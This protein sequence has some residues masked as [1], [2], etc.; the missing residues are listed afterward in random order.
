MKK[1]VKIVLVLAAGGAAVYFLR[2]KSANAS[3]S[4]AQE[5]EGP[6][7]DYAGEAVDTGTPQGSG[8]PVGTKVLDTV[9]QM[10]ANILAGVGKVVGGK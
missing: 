7:K 3:T 8:K 9:K 5:L 4:E 10:A 2:S 1:P 6:P